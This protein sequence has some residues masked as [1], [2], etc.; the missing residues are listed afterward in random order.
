MLKGDDRLLGGGPELAVDA[1]MR[2]RLEAAIERP[3]QSRDPLPL[4]TDAQT[5]GRGIDPLRI[6][7]LKDLGGNPPDQPMRLVVVTVLL[8][9]VLVRQHAQPRSDRSVQT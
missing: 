2:A 4:R 1:Q 8:V 7:V 9:L 3:L 6:E 5:L